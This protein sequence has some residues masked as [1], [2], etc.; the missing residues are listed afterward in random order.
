MTDPRRT[1]GSGCGEFV[2]MATALV[3]GAL[4]PAQERRLVDHVRECEGCALFLDRLRRTI[5]ALDPPRAQ[6]PST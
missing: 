2:E 1:A 4:D 6:R 5:S 3:D